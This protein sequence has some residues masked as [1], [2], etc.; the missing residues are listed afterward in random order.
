MAAL[1]TVLGVASEGER[2]V[3]ITEDGQ[4]AFDPDTI[5]ELYNVLT[6]FLPRCWTA[7]VYYGYDAPDGC[8]MPNALCVAC[9]DQARRLPS[10][11]QNSAHTPAT[12]HATIPTAARLLTERTH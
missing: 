11:R 2:L 8:T 7:H 1:L 3:S 6:D 5:S 10:G 9:V 12:T 4:L